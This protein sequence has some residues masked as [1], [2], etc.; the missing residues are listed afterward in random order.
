MP[1]TNE[2][3]NGLYAVYAQSAENINALHAAL[4]SVAKNSARQHYRDSF[5]T[6]TPKGKPLAPHIVLDLVHHVL[7]KLADGKFS[8]RCPFA[9][10]VRI[11]FRNY[12]I[13]EIRKLYL[14]DTNEL[15]DE[16]VSQ[17]T[18][19]IENQ[20][21][22]RADED[23]NEYE[24]NGEEEK[25][26]RR[27]GSDGWGLSPISPEGLNTKTGE[28]ELGAFDRLVQGGYSPE[29]IKGIVREFLSTLNPID[30]QIVLLRLDKAEYQEIAEELGISEDHARYR[31]DK[32]LDAAQK[33]G[34]SR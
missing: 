19:R 8:G 31:F 25:S 2:L 30:M 10:W 27:H 16:G 20:F 6:F 14:P 32:T 24:Y 26:T 7:G 22:L 13:S 1:S 15:K 33:F 21:D 4:L 34:A 23:G 17:E 28:V 11:V 18:R 5:D 12:C 9:A 3:L 29:E